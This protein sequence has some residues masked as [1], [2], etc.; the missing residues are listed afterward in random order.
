MTNPSARR[1]VLVTGAAA[2]LAGCSKYG[3]EGGDGTPESSSAGSSKTGD[4]PGGEELAGTGDIPVGGGKIF[5]EQKI[6]VTQP[7]KG[8]FKAFSA[9]CT[10]AG[11]TVA[12]VSDGTINC[13]CHGSKFRIEDASVADGPAPRPLPAEK[14][15]VS[16]NSIRRG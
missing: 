7:E 9:V 16:G 15:T 5:K 6:V 13:P 1:T 3:D 10:H 2:L 8:D 4:A 12:S 14:I 11:C